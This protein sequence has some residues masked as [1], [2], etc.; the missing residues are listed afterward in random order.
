MTEEENA[1]L[2]SKPRRKNSH[3]AKE[4]F[5]NLIEIPEGT[6][7]TE[8]QYW[9]SDES[10]ALLE[11]LSNESTL[12]EYNPGGKRGAELLL[13]RGFKA[14]YL[15]YLFAHLARGKSYSTFWGISHDIIPKTRISKFEKEIPEWNYVKELGE[16]AHMEK[17]EST[18]ID[19]VEG[20]LGKNANGAVLV[21]KMKSLFDSWNPEKKSFSLNQHVISPGADGKL[22]LN[23]QVHDTARIL[24][25][26]ETLNVE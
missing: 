9:D 19:I 4:E 22:Q 26:E 6:V 11:Y 23:F 7:M 5:S 25:N 14:K 18:M 24:T 8:E 21:A 15:K 20:N 1:R 10:D 16:I 2:L 13:I 12:A 3:M 17:W